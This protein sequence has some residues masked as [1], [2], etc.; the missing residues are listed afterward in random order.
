MY[1][2]I[3]KVF[4]ITNLFLFFL[5]ITQQHNQSKLKNTKYLHKA[6]IIAKG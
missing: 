6:E 2:K 4:K 1:T 5:Q 3:E